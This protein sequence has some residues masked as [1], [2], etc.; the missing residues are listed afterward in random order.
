MMAALAALETKGIGILKRS[1]WYESAPVPASDQPWFINGVVSIITSSNPYNLMKL[2]QEI[3][4]DF[5]R[6]RIAPNAA[7][8]LDLDLL[9]YGDL[10]IDRPGPD[11]LILPHPRLAERAFVLLPWAEISPHWRHPVT[12]KTVA[13]MVAE[14]PPRPGCRP[15][16][17]DS[18]HPVSNDAMR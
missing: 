18:A 12:G 13:A 8:P 3:E 4:T 7:R 17:I 1:R 14:L 16:E 15:L 6:T 9:A 5:G 10:V 11:G 2:T